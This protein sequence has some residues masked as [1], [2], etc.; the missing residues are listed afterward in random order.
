MKIICRPNHPLHAKKN[1]KIKDLL[2]YEWATREQGSGTFDIFFNALKENTS[3]IKKAI[4][5]S[6]SEAIKQYVAHSDCLAC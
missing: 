3:S 1:I 4:T 6:N 5:L 2:K